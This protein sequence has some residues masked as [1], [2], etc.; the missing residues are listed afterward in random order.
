M[1]GQA[2]Q[3]LLAAGADL[4][5]GVSREI[6]AGE[7]GGE[8]E[9]GRGSGRGG[10]DVRDQSD[11]SGFFTEE[12]ALGIARCRSNG[13]RGGDGDAVE[14]IDQLECGRG[15]S[16]GHI[17]RGIGHPQASGFEGSRAEGCGK[18]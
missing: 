2:N 18:H 17:D 7:Q 11:D 8:V 16:G 9:K 14:G 15:W 10:S 1:K 3:S 4:F 6:P 13:G 12:Q 5:V